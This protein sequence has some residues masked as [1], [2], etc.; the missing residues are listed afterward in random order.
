M[1]FPIVEIFLASALLVNTLA[2][3]TDN[4]THSDGSIQKTPLKPLLNSNDRFKREERIESALRGLLQVRQ[5]SCS[6]GSFQCPAGDGCCP[7]GGDCCSDG[8]CCNTAQLCCQGG[9]CCELN[10]VCATDETTGERGCCPVGKIC[11]GS[12]S[13]AMGLE[14]HP[15]LYTGF[16][17]AS[18]F[19]LYVF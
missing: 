3:T 15:A 19:F 6:I 7:D 2:A 18:A 9:G 8:R 11:T 10:D 13:A 12:T 5:S 16:V 17:T 14:V 4:G 1:R